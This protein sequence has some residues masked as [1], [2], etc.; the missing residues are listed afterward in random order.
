MINQQL[1][2]Q[3]LTALHQ[4]GKVVNIQPLTGGISASMTLID[5]ELLSGKV[6]RYIV[7]QLSAETLALRPNAVEMEY[8]LLQVLKTHGLPVS[9]PIYLDVQGEIFETPTL[10]MDYLSGD[11]DF[12]A[13][14]QP[15]RGSE[16]AKVLARIHTLDL[17]EIDHIA[18]PHLEKSFLGLCGEDPKIPDEELNETLIWNQLKRYWPPRFQNPPVLLHGDI[19][20]G[21]ILWQGNEISGII[22][23]EDAWIGDPLLDIAGARSDLAYT[24]GM[25]MADQLTKTYLDMRKIDA[26]DLP[27]WDLVAVL[28]LIRF[29]NHDLPAWAAFFNRF[30]RV[31]ITAESIKRDINSFSNQAL[32]KLSRKI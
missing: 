10:V 3:L 11:M 13:H 20:S 26:H 14:S 19:W 28:W 7:R 18:V 24:F 5:V 32:E 8:G 6:N 25:E 2:E 21:N 29:I 12:S 31:D 23:W 9:C 27:L 30:G 22:D 1:I 4:Q 16:I 17:K 15:N